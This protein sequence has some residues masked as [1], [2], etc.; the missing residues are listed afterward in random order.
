MSLAVSSSCHC[1]QQ[2]SFLQFFIIIFI[3]ET[4]FTIMYLSAPSL[5]DVI[6]II[7]MNISSIQRTVVLTSGG[8]LDHAIMMIITMTRITIIIIIII[9]GPKPA[10]GRQGLV[11]SWGQDKDEVSTFLVF[12]TSHLAPVAL[13]SDFTNLGP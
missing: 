4:G 13:S 7:N 9:T 5:P 11:G 10:S 8:P 3:I 2:N 1:Q 6:V 12:L